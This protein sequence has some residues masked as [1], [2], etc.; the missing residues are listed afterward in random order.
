MRLSVIIPIFN[1][2]DNI[3]ILSKKLDNS[4][5]NFNY[6]VIFIN[7]GSTDGSEKKI[8]SMIILLILKKTMVRLLLYRQDLTFQKE[9]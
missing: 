2:K 1:E 3:S 6:E 7:D 9:T 4:L 8:L 5:K